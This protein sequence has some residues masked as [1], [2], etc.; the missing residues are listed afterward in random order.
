M[1]TVSKKSNILTSEEGQ[2]IRAE[3]EAI[4]NDKRYRTK[5]TYSANETDFPD[6]VMPFVEK[7]M[8]YLSKHSE[9]NPQHYLSNLRLK[10]KIRH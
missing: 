8:L 6:H 7:H 9:L 3:L 10:I 5:D 2:Q 1:P 4:G